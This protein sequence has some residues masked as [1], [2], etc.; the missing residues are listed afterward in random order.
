MAVSIN[1]TKIAGGAVLTLTQPGYDVRLTGGPQFSVR[2]TTT[3]VPNAS[4]AVVTGDGLADPAKLTASGKIFTASRSTTESAA[5]TVWS[6]LYAEQIASG[7]FKVAMS[8][9]SKTYTVRLLGVSSEFVADT[10]DQWG[11]ITIDMLILDPAT[12]IV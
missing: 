3:V 8:N 10:G 12:D 2:N 7:G 1:F 6:L 4:G 9:G 5:Y 11:T